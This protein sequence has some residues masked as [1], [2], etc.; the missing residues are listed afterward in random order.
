MS[1]ISREAIRR[2][3]RL[4]PGDPG[5]LVVTPLLS[6]QQFSDASLDLRLG[7]QFIVFRPHTRGIINPFDLPEHDLR[8]LQERQVVQFRHKFVLHP[9]TLA[10]AC[11]FEYVRLPGDL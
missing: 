8:G 5:R 9:G 3:L 7:N 6:E 1:T 11:S 10:L 2:R 4:E